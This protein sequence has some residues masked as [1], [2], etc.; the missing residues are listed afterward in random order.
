MES[1]FFF[2]HIRRTGG[3]VDKQIDICDTLDIAKRSFR[4]F[5]GDYGYGVRQDTDFVSGMVTDS[6]G[7]IVKPYD[8]TWI[9]TNV[10]KFFMHRIKHTETNDQ[11]D[12][13]IEVKDS[14]DAAKQ[15]FNAYLGA[16]AYGFGEGVDFVDCRI[17]DSYGAQLMG[18]MWAAPEPEP[19]PEVI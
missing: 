2:H 12:K 15:S 17:T 9:S 18:E 3:T 8:E 16:W 4:K 7:N 19:E 14:Y 13:G 6:N 11:W 1:K 10:G 5:M